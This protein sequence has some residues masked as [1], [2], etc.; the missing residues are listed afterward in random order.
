MDTLSDFEMVFCSVAIFI[1]YCIFEGV[2][3]WLM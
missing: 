3:T 1:V 2:I